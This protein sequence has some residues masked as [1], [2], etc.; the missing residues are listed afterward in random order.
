[1]AKEK[2]SNSSESFITKIISS[3]FKSTDPEFEK[4]K[5]IKA[6]AKNLT[7][8]RYRFYKPG[9]DEVLPAFAK[10]FYDIYKAVFPAKA[11]FQAQQNPNVFKQ[12]LVDYCLNDKQHEIV[13]ALSEE[14]IKAQSAS[15]PVDKLNAEVKKNIDAF[16][17]IFTT[18]K[19]QQIESLYRKLMLFKSFCL[20]DFYFLLKKFDSSLR[21]GEFTGMPK[22]EKINSE[23]IGEDLKE[24]LAVAW[25]LPEGEDWSDL[26]KFFK[27]LKGTEPIPANLWS[28][29][30]SKINSIKVSRVFEM[31]IQVI[32]KDPDYFP[33]ISFVEETIADAYIDRVRGDAEKTLR[34]LA[35]EQQNSKIDNLLM[36]IFGTTEI[37]RMHNYIE[38]NSVTY[39]KR[40]L[41][42]FTYMRPLNFYKAFLLDF[43]KK[44]VREFADLVLVRGTWST[45][46][47][48]TPMSNAY[49]ELIESSNTLT[50]FDNKIA[51]DG[52]WGIKLKTLLPRTERD[53]EA[54]SIVGTTLNDIN[55][56]ARS[57]CVEGTKNLITIAKTI[58]TILDDYAKPKGELII[59]W[60]ELEHFADHPIKELGVGVYKHIYL[61]VNLMQSCLQQG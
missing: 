43:I 6:I 40:S 38:S 35:V 27:A 13:E 51:E 31:M 22:F 30:V 10:L 26:M 8:A 61:F 25:V 46:T 28:K 33:D 58:K 39:E 42:G 36:Q 60:K 15:M 3:I 32:S 1:M 12:M 54:R 52:E 34:S 37:V 56:E 53:K 4:K 5:K 50:T 48:S 14:S 23:Y 7:K 19:V 41:G 47:L 16:S 17:A 11:M 45:N 55:N 18:E 59:N 9:S 2:S 21:E 57:F 29:I 24:F 20:Y 44:D 49:N